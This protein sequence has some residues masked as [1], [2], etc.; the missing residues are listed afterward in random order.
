MMSE[1]TKLIARLKKKEISVFD[2]PIEYRDNTELLAFERKAGMR[3]TGKRGF[4]IINNSFFVE[5]TFVH[6]DKSHEEK[7]ETVLTFDDFDSYYDYLNGDIYENACY[8]FCHLSKENIAS[9]KVDLNRLM[10]RKAFIEEIIAD[11]Q[12]STTDEEKKRYSDA[13]RTHKHCQEWIKKFNNCYSYDEFINVVNNYKKSQIASIVDISFFFFQYIF[14]DTTNKKR[15]SIIME[16]MSTGQYPEF[17]MILGLCSIYNPDDV[18]QS[19]NY[20]LGAKSTIRKRKAELKS[21]IQHLKD[22]E[23]ELGSHAFFDERTHYYCEEIYAPSVLVCRYFESFDEFVDYRNGDLR[24]CDLSHALELNVD[25]SNYIVDE[26]TKLPIHANTEVLYSVKKY[27]SDRKFYVIQRWYKRNGNIIKESK[28]SFNYFFD[29]VKFLNGDLSGANLISCNGLMFLKQWD[30]I[31]FTGAKMRSSLCEKFGIKYDRQE[32]KQSLIESFECAEKNE[33][34]TALVFQMS[35]ELTLNDTKAG[36]SL[37]NV[38]DSYE[39]EKVYYISD[40]HLMHRIQCAGCCSK[41][42]IVYVVQNI[43]STISSEAGDLLLIGGDVSSDFQIF[44]LFVKILSKK[45]SCNT[46]VVFTLGNHELW[47]FPDYSLDKIISKYRG[48]LSKYGMYLLHNDIFYSDGSN[49]ETYL[50]QYQ[51]LCQMSDAQISRRLQ[52]ARYIILG[53]LGFSGYNMEFNGDNGIYQGIINRSIEIRE[54]KRFEDLYSRLY[55][56]LSKKNTIIL[57][58]TPKKDWCSEARYDKHFVYVSGHTHRNYFH[59]DGEYRIYSD[60]QIGYHNNNPHLKNFLIDNDYDYFADYNDGVFEITREQYIDF[61]RGKNITMTFQR[62]VN[63]LYMLKKN[64]Y[65]CFICESTIGNLMILNGGS[66]KKLKKQ[67]IQYY[68]NNMDKMIAM[69][70]S[71]YDKFNAFQMVIAN[72]IKKLG[73][74]GT[75]H[76]CI[77]D[78]DLYSHIYVNPLDLSITGYWASDIVNKV[79]YSSVPALLEDRCPEVYG[80]YVKLLAS[81]KENPLAVKQRMDITLLPQVYLDTDIYKASR[82]IKKMHKLC[83]NILSSWYENTIES[84]T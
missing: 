45:I 37:Y 36:L 11:C 21:H 23:I 39:C 3:I 79:V 61:C 69:I 75:I 66:F 9:R 63:A 40:L 20:S 17:K 80:K 8:T 29:F 33:N 82:E 42:D 48:I 78:I 19:Y 13:E 58:H 27:Y 5:E 44:Q 28:H 53:G 24:H 49:S 57:T 76:G 52:S 68:Y 47:S 7:E 35:R 34:E 55:S 26:T 83:S 65:Y 43:V 77:I 81:S 71:P 60:N 14:A 12:L 4:D 51:E 10:E 38:K 67:N 50:I 56:I 70:K 41:E 62:P 32:I 16:Y 1:I 54:S 64:G 25:F 31:N 30:T 72:E 74:E 18:M 73:G 2:I 59:D 6:I 15:F 46:T 22:G 84:T